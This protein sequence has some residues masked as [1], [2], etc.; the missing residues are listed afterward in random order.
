VLTKAIYK[1]VFSKTMKINSPNQAIM[2]NYSEA[3]ILLNYQRIW[4]HCTEI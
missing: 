1:V 3:T 2:D 4:W